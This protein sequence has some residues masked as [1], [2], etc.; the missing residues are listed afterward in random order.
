[1]NY[2]GL[3]QLIEIIIMQFIQ[4]FILIIAQG[5]D[6]YVLL[7]IIMIRLMIVILQY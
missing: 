2:N 4:L 1:M 5:I 3:A 6:H 7:T